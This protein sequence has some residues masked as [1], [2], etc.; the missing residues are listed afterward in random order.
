MRAR[1]RLRCGIPHEPHDVAGLLLRAATLAFVAAAVTLAVNQSRRDDDE[2][3]DVPPAAVLVDPLATELARCRTI[4]PEQNAADDTC[5]RAWAESRRRF[6]APSSSLS[7]AGTN[8]AVAAGPVKSQ[9][10]L[11]SAGVEPDRDEVR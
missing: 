7:D 5:R 2:N 11:P 1:L 3:R 8:A 4:T 9:D 10:R 6:F